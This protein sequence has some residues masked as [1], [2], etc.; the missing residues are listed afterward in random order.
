MRAL[1]EHN[2]IVLGRIAVAN[3]IENVQKRLVALAEHLIEL[4]Q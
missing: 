2:E 1:V 4:E 3:A